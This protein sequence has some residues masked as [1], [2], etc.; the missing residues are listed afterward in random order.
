MKKLLATLICLVMIVS[1]MVVFTACGGSGSDNNSDILNNGQNNEQ[2][3]EQ[4]NGDEQVNEKEEVAIN[5][6]K[7]NA[8]PS[9]LVANKIA[10]IDKTRILIYD[11]GYLYSDAWGSYRG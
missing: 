5:E 7:G 10:S 1:V 9:K 2:N 11:G 3:N 6:E 8:L 4:N